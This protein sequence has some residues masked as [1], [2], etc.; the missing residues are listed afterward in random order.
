MIINLGHCELSREKRSSCT[1]DYAKSIDPFMQSTAVRLRR[2]TG[3]FLR[4]MADAHK[5]NFAASELDSESR[6][7]WALLRSTTPS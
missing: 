3:D 6:E 5:G 4:P 2:V 1:Y 7:T